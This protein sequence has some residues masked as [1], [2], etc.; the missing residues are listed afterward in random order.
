[1]ASDAIELIKAL[2][3]CINDDFKLEDTNKVFNLVESQ[4]GQT[5]VVTTH[6]G[7]EILCID[8]DKKR[9]K[10]EES[11]GLSKDPTFP[12]FDPKEVGLL[13]RN[14]AIFFSAQKG[15]LFVFLIEMKQGHKGDYL[16]QLK[17]GRVF[18]KFILEML[19]LHDK[20]VSV[21]A[22]FFGVL[23][24]EPVRKSVD[25]ETTRHGARYSFENRN[26]LMTC[27]IYS[28]EAD[29]QQLMNAA[30]RSMAVS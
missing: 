9:I 15:D 6:G 29:L 17:A 18:V 14:D 20:C 22:N 11:G 12:F 23:C 21:V 28:A 24:H 5:L 16:L 7:A 10:S 27:E 26:G 19:E 30:R 8:I 3:R 13:K 25:K 1:M 2:R 4:N